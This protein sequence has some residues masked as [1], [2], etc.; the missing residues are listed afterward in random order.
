MS[1]DDQVNGLLKK[2]GQIKRND[3]LVIENSTPMYLQSEEIENLPLAVPISVI[4]KATNGKD[5][6]H[7]IKKEKIVD[8]QKGIKKC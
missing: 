1:W 3:T 8:L 4:T 2:S 7:S 5:V 6:S